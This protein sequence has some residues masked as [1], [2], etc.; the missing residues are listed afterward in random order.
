[1]YINVGFK[2]SVQ[3]VHHVSVLNQS[4]RARNGNGMSSKY[5]T[6]LKSEALEALPKITN[7]ARDILTEDKFDE[8]NA[9]ALRAYPTIPLASDRYMRVIE[10]FTTFEDDLLQVLTY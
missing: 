6:G 1:M 4:S 10:D 3:L 5:L 2:E 7:L 9:R 8:A